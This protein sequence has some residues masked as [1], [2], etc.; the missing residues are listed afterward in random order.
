VTRARTILCVDD[1]RALAENLR[2]ILE[3][4]GYAVRTAASCAEA[5]E[6]ARPG[7]DVALVDVRL[8]DGDGTTLA[9][10]LRAIVPDAQ[11]IMLTGFA[12]VESAVAAVRAGAWA[13][14][15]KPCAMPELL[16][17][18]EQ[19]VRQIQNIEE[20][21]ELERRARVAEKLAA[22]GT[23]T[24]G[25]SH[26]IKNPLNAAALQLAVVERRVKRLP[27]EVQQALGEPLKL[28]QD[29]IARLNGILEDFLAFARPREIEPAPVDVTAVLGRVVDLLSAQADRVEVKIERRWREV[30]AVSGDSG[31]LQ[32]AFVN[33][34]LNAIQATPPGGVVTL[35]MEPAGDTVRIAVE[36][37]GPGIP[38]ALRTRIFEPFFTTKQ[39]GSG[40]GLALVHSIVDQHHGS[41]TVEQG[42]TGGARFVLDLPVTPA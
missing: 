17:A 38:E 32:Q 28:V 3:D 15:L 31:R 30:P 5:L 26:E 21:N 9:G 11:V 14:L 36:D 8:P 10:S 7:F 2:E 16:V 40:I 39:A 20:R 33:L 6:Q 22:I 13:Y 25:L 41:I 1:N 34:L 23:M 27:P 12:T 42:E 19:A 37:S 4:A 29:E 18:V 24:A 35:A